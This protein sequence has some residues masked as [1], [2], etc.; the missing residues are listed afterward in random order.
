M[1][2]AFKNFLTTLRRYKTASALNIAGLT[3]AFTAFYVMMAQVT[4]DLGYDRSFPESDRLYTVVPH[5][6]RDSY[7][8]DAPADMFPSVVEQCPE[9]EARRQDDDRQIVRRAE[10][11]NETN[12]FKFVFNYVTESIVDLLGFRAVE[13]DLRGMFA[14]DGVMVSRS[15]A[16]KM[17]LHAGDIV[18][19]P[20]SPDYGDR[21]FVEV[22]VT[23]ICEDFPDNSFLAG[24]S[25]VSPLQ[26]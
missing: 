9:V 10:K 14:S 13:G 5:F 4:Y 8:V 16:E 23:G 19:V 12:R 24:G 1:K 15:V 2:I 22:V 6:Y 26:G 3:M 21:N 25:R 20:D 11:G 17:K 18:L 7:V